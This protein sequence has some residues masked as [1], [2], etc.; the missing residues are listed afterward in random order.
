VD[1]QSRHPNFA[2]AANLAW[3]HAGSPAGCHIRQAEGTTMRMRY[4]HLILTG[5]LTVAAVVIL[6]LLF[7]GR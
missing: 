2:S 4:S 5:L 3:P 1:K 6:A 7:G